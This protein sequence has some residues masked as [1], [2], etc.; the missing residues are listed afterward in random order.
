M[1]R[2]TRIAERCR[3]SRGSFESVSGDLEYRTRLHSA[4]EGI[5][6]CGISKG[7]ARGK[8]SRESKHIV[9][10]Q[11]PTP[12]WLIVKYEINRMDVLTSHLV[13]GE[14][15]LP[16]FSFKEE[17]GMFFEH[18]ALGN[19]WQVRETTAG[20]LI[21]ILFGPCASADR[22]AL[23]PLPEID[24]EMLIYLASMQ[25]EDFVE[26]LMGKQK[27]WLSVKERGPTHRALI[28]LQE[29]TSR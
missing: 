8:T 12:Y 26:F 2:P 20:E 19:R 14:E 17:A 10:A 6:R 5:D 15:A 4:A 16:V 29:I 28:P 13:G 18:L 24:V 27:L 25:R 21:S 3:N 1:P 7:P 9:N 11:R 23:D 22:V